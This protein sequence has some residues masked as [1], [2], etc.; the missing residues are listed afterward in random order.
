[1]AFLVFSRTQAITTKKIQTGPTKLPAITKRVNE[2]TKP[3]AI[4]AAAVM[5]NPLPDCSRRIPYPT[6]NPRRPDARYPIK[7]KVEICTT[8]LERT[9]ITMYRLVAIPSS[10]RLCS[11]CPA[12]GRESLSPQF[13]QNFRLGEFE[14]PH[15]G[16]LTELCPDSF[17]ISRLKL[18]VG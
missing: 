1:M 2:K 14:K 12:L 16:H 6:Y 9:E 8:L 17:S 18:G 11:I 7:K 13:P 4:D 5:T 15:L 10:A 3:T